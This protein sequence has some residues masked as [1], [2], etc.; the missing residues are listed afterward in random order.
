MCLANCIL[1]IL[2]LWANIHLSVRSSFSQ[3]M[4]LNNAV[5]SY[6]RLDVCLTLTPSTTALALRLQA[7]ATLLTFLAWVLGLNL[8]PL[9]SN[10]GILT[11]KLPLQP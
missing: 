10:V 1:G 3:A 6:I 9:N 8:D 2:S 7:W 4:D 5:T 11:S